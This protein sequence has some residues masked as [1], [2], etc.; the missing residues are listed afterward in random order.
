MFEQDEEGNLQAAH[1]PFTAP[2]EETI[3]FLDSHPLKV[4][5]RS[6]DLVLNGYELSSGSIRIH[7]QD[8]QRKMFQVLKLTD[9]EINNKFGFFINAF[10][11]GAPPHGGLAFGIDRLLMILSKSKSIREVIAFP[12]NANGID[13]ML[14]SPSEVDDQQLIEYKLKKVNNE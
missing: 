11:Y 13:V 2:K 1:H 9:E 6:Y 4:K 7:N 3:T 8:L 10:Q 14:Q 12:K 5:A